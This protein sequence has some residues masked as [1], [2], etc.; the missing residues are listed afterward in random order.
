MAVP[1]DGALS[2]EIAAQDNSTTV[3]T[4]TICMTLIAT[5]FITLRMYGCIFILRRRLYFEEWL[6]VVNQVRL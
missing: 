3:V 2:P 6:T 4:V 1:Q 5:F